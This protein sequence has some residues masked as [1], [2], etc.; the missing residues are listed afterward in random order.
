LKVLIIILIIGIFIVSG[1]TNYQYDYDEEAAVKRFS[2]DDGF[3]V[4]DNGRSGSLVYIEMMATGTRGSYE[5]T[6][7]IDKSL[8]NLFFIYNIEHPEDIKDLSDA[9]LKQLGVKRDDFISGPELERLKENYITLYKVSLT[10]PTETCSYWINR[11]DYIKSLSTY[12][13]G[14]NSNT[15]TPAE[16]KYILQSSERCS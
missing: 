14:S 16:M 5:W 1:C 6:N 12:N 13:A 15:M 10:T 7:Q 9:E 3:E 2:I 4:I 8:L 11:E